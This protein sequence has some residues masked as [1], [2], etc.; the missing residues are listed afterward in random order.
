M[1]TSKSKNS[2]YLSNNYSL[3]NKRAKPHSESKFYDMKGFILNET[4]LN[5]IEQNEVGDVKGKSL[6]HLQCH[7]GQD[8]LSWARNGAFVTGI[9][10]SNTAIGLA[11]SLSCELDIPASFICADIYNLPTVLDDKFDI[12]FTSYGVIKWLP[13]VWRWAEIIAQSLKPS[14]FFY[15]VEFHPFIYVLDYE[16]AERI[17]HSYFHTTEPICYE[18]VGSYAMPESSESHPAYAWSHTISDI[19]NALLAVELKLEFIH[20]FPYSVINCFPFVREDG[21]GKYVHSKYP[22]MVPMLYSIKATK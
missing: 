3:W 9:D 14:G 1:G 10:F 19:V 11:K 4:S 21:L 7:F 20:E 22:N 8:T 6:L 12:V 5:S 2:Y 16:S 15:M 18:E 17:E 13:D